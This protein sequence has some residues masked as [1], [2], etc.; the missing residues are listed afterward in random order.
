[1]SHTR[2]E[3]SRIIATRAL[4]SVAAIAGMLILGMG[5][6]EH[7]HSGSLE[8]AAPPASQAQS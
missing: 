8:P 1:M 3:Y 2:P 5:F 4:I 7:A 6:S